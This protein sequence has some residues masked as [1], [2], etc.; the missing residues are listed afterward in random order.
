MARIGRIV[1]HIGKHKTGSSSIQASLSGVEQDGFCYAPL[2]SDNHASA[3]S[4]FSRRLSERKNKLRLRGREEA[5]G[6][7][8]M[9]LQHLEGVLEGS[10]R[11]LFFSAEML[12]NFKKPEVEGL[13][14]YLSGYTD[15]I[16]VVGF[17]RPP[18][19]SSVSAFQER[20]KHGWD[21]DHLPKGVYR[22]SFAPY[23]ARLGAEAVHILPFVPS[24][25]VNGSLVDTLLHAI[26]EPEIVY[27]EK[28]MNESM[29][30]DA[31]KLLYSFNRSGRFQKLGQQN[32][33]A[34]TRLWKMV[35]ATI[36]GAKLQLPADCHT[37]G[38][39]PE[40]V[41]WLKSVTGIDF[42]ADLEGMEERESR[43]SKRLLRAMRKISDD[44]VL[45]LQDLVRSETKRR[46]SSPLE[47]MA[48]LYQAYGGSE[49]VA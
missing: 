19:S 2:P 15:R 36:A 1:L 37:P 41:E 44:A 35:G 21:R 38:R 7:R 26:G 24:Q 27:E 9:N 40:E 6:R 12:E 28:R 34:R 46:V 42:T 10:C 48:A 31:V 33:R 13:I 30:G 32:V 20:I 14:D 16:E 17:V 29:A 8:G 45:Q 22:K 18:R 11:T 23:I 43:A 4:V 5:K 25:F 3:F 47:G 49:E 39:A